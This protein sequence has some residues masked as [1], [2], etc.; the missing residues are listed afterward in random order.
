MVRL[1]APTVKPGQLPVRV[2]DLT[3]R[4]DEPDGWISRPAVC[5][6]AITGAAEGASRAAERSSRVVERAGGAPGAFSHADKRVRELAGKE[7]W[8][9]ERMITSARIMR[10]TREI[11]KYAEGRTRPGPPPRSRGGGHDPQNETA[12]VKRRQF[13][14]QLLSEIYSWLTFV[15]CE[16]TAIHLPPFFSNTSVPR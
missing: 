10:E 7:S 15:S 4:L 5:L 2:S 11:G 6:A 9:V 14:E 1:N 13:H 8:G 12:A 3:P 16:A